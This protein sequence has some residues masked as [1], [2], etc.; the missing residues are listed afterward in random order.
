LSSEVDWESKY[1]AASIGWDLDGPH[2]YLN[3]LM[4]LVEKN[5]VLPQ[6]SPARALVPGCGLGHAAAYFA[7]LGYDACGVDL[8]PTAMD[9]A[10]KRYGGHSCRFVAGDFF[11]ADLQSQSFDLIY[12]RAMYCA[13]DV[14]TRARY[15]AKCADLLKP[16]GIFLSILFAEIDQQ[17]VEQG[18]PFAADFDA[19]LGSADKHGMSLIFRQDKAGTGPKAIVR[20]S[21]VGFLK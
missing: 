10:T 14:E 13:L 6:K 21:L 11:T 3:E 4:V 18:P 16:G 20:E 2:I 17:M 7:K 9:Q 5:R 15:F 8:S 19:L 12:D 1:A